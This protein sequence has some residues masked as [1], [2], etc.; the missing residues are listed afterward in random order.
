MK[1]NLFAL[2]LTA[3]VLLCATA[4]C[5][6]DEEK[7][8]ESTPVT[9]KAVDYQLRVYMTVSQL[10]YLDCE[11]SVLFPGKEEQ[12]VK[13][14]NG[15]SNIVKA[16]TVIDNK[17]IA[18]TEFFES[19][20]QIYACLFDCN[21]L[22]AGEAKAKIT[23]SRNAVECK[24][25]AETVDIAVGALWTAKTDG[26]LYL[27]TEGDQSFYGGVYARDLGEFLQTIGE[28]FETTYSITH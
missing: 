18:L 16:D 7:T 17:I 11:V 15:K 2:I 24:D 21:G 25:T 12:I 9:E 8:A 6:K 20:P 26:H 4:S 5:G 19:K 23:F 10:K 14:E 1:K 22:R 13:V 28:T 27:Q 3:A